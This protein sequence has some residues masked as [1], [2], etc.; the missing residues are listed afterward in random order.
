MEIWLK[1]LEKS[2]KSPGN[3]LVKMCKNPVGKYFLNRGNK[4]KNC[5]S[6]VVLNSSWLNY[7]HTR[8]KE[9]LSWT[10]WCHK[11]VRR[12]FWSFFCHLERTLFC[13]KSFSLDCV[14]LS[15]GFSESYF[16][17]L[18]K[19]RLKNPPLTELVTEEVYK[20][21]CWKKRCVLRSSWCILYFTLTW[22]KHFGITAYLK[23]C[24]KMWN[25]I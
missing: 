14:L 8:S 25:T 24:G 23:K 2:W 10:F 17:R 21:H 22:I 5:D 15:V 9:Q 6:I 3:P 13:N 18:L 11:N 4:K 20:W 12:C 16:W 1:V 19:R 7:F